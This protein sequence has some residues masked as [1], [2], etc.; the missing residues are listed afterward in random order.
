MLEFQTHDAPTCE[1]IMWKSRCNENFTVND[2]I[3]ATVKRNVCTNARLAD[4][5]LKN[6]CLF[7]KLLKYRTFLIDDVDA[8]KQSPSDIQHAMYQQQKR[9]VCHHLCN[10][11]GIESKPPLS[12]S[13]ISRDSHVIAWATSLSWL[14]IFLHTW[15]Y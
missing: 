5:H 8:F 15:I 12:Q 10:L 3:C 2:N 9:F 13:F 1:C 6:R 14:T 4:I 7:I 11:K